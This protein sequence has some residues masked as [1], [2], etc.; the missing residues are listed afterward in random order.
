MA[1]FGAKYPSL[2]V[3]YANE[4]RDMFSLIRIVSRTILV[5]FLDDHFRAKRPSG[6]FFFAKRVG[7]SAST[8]RNIS[9]RSK[10]PA[11]PIFRAN[12]LGGDDSPD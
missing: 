3:F 10:H 9:L 5:F 4:V 7:V 8:S 1:T 6:I 11:K 12:R 2:P